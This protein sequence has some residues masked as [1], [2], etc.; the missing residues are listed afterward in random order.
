[1]NGSL[2]VAVVT[3][4]ALAADS[5]EFCSGAFERRPSQAHHQSRGLWAHR[6]AVC[7][8][9]GSR[10]IVIDG[11][12]RSGVSLRRSLPRLRRKEGLGRRRRRNSEAQNLSAGS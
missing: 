2:R 4:R 7:A 5:I 8:G 1:M 10:D 11:H 3:I 12:R 6:R 9:G